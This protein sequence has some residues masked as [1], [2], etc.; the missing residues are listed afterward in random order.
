MAALDKL[1]CDAFLL[2]AHVSFEEQVRLSEKLRLG[3]LLVPVVDQKSTKYEL[4][5]FAN[6]EGWS[7]LHT[8]TILTSGSTGEPKAVQHTWESLYRPVR[9]G[10]ENCAPRWLLTYRPNLYAGL[11]VVLQCFAD[12]GTLAAADLDMDP[13]SIA[14]L[15]CDASVQFVSATPSYWR[16]LLIFVDSA[17]LRRVPLVQITL[18]GEVIDQPILDSLRHHFPTARLVHIYATTELGRC[19]SVGDG[20]AGFPLHY[21]DSP[22]PDGTEL[23]L[24]EGELLVRSPNSM[25]MYDRLS[26]QQEAA[27]NWFPTGDLAEIR[28]GRV[29]FVGRRTEMINVAGSKVYPLE[30]ER[31]IRIIPGVADVRVFGKAS[32]ITGQMVGC[33]IVPAE[34]YNC[35]RLREEIRRTCRAKLS[36]HQQPRLIKFIGRIDLS[37]AGKTL[38]SETV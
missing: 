22:L 9:K 29:Q 16:R 30:V 31:V 28:N 36:S 11:Q 27:S 23:S 34:G 17:L 15:M 2:D 38:R 12:R 32:S 8:V 3:A 5:E 21:L 7:G 35:D 37:I 19:F 1:G 33:E 25:R 26:P 24:R 14:R 20:F 10:P 4:H 6:E 13:H 18:G